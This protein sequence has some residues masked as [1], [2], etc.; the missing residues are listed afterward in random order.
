MRTAS[1]LEYLR[2]KYNVEV[3]TFREPGA[4]MPV[5]PDG[6]RSHVIDLPFHSKTT[7]ARGLR[8]MRRAWRGVPPLVD[9]FG[10]FA[11]EMTPFLRDRRYELGVI[12]HFWCAAYVRTLR[13]VCGRIALDL[14]NIE[15][16]LLKRQSETATLPASVVLRR[17]ASQCRRLESEYL[18]MYDDLLVTSEQDRRITGRGTVYPNAV[19]EVAMPVVARRDEIA[20]SGNL[21]YEPNITAVR[22]FYE[23]IWP[24]VRRLSPG[25]IWRLVGR[26]E[27][28]VRSIVGADPSVALTGPVTDAVS[29]IARARV[30]VVPLRSGSGTRVKIIEAWA[31]GVP[32]VST[33][34][35]AEGLPGVHGEHLLIADSPT[36]FARCI[37][38]VLGDQGLARRLGAAGRRLYESKLTWRA[39]WKSLEEAGF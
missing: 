36:G 14:H 2:Q 32:V 30:A 8:N 16:V 17:F 1:L 23:A 26:N 9:R 10:G 25:F 34:I 15:S 13:P 4:P 38:R 22:W 7:L 19:G 20:F 39:A 11:S 37:E 5:F 28:A 3:I 33:A 21:E 29:E 24:E 18:P 35:G 12:E 31:A 6:I 27:H